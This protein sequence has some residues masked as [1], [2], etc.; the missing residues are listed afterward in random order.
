MSDEFDDFEEKIITN[1]L[2]VFDEIAYDWESQYGMTKHSDGTF[3]INKLYIGPDYMSYKT[4]HWTLGPGVFEKVEKFYNLLYPSN[5]VDF[6]EK[7]K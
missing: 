6:L 5:S 2:D 7:I 4:Q 3:S 1:F